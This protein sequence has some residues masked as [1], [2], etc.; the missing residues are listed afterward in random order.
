MLTIR[1]FQKHP[2]FIILAFDVARRDHTIKQTSI[3]THSRHWASTE[4][5]LES[6]TPDQLKEA[7]NQAQQYK[8]IENPAVRALLR[9]VDR[10]GAH[11]LGSDA[12]RFHMF[13]ELKSSVV[14]YGLPVVY[15][16]LNP[17]ERHSPLARVYAG[18]D[19]DVTDFCPDYYNLASRME[20]M[21]DHPLAVVKYF[22]TTLR[23][24][25]SSLIKGGLFG[26]VLHHYGTIEY[27]GRGTPHIHLLVRLY[28]KA[29][30]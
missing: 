3:H 8:P 17:G 21:L 27:Q 28:P 4:Q 11:A 12:K 13:A 29:R 24:I 30:V 9:S 16:T 20:I 25:L 1:R 7:A 5:L 15:L 23:T 26:E 2:Q 18:E 6:L 10:V 14:Y 22:H 19:I